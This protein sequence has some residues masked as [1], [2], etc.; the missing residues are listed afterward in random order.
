MSD[1]ITNSS[2]SGTESDGPEAPHFAFN[3]GMLGAFEV[4]QMQIADPWL[5]RSM[6]ASLSASRVLDLMKIGSV[7][8]T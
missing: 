8:V 1:N 3:E 2:E 6:T 5:A 7:G 4:R